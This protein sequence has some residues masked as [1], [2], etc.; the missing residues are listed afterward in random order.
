[1]MTSQHF[2][3][4]AK[5]SQVL[6]LAMLVGSI[7]TVGA[8]VAPTEFKTHPIESA[9]PLMGKVFTKL[10]GVMQASLILFSLAVVL[11]FLG[12]RVKKHQAV[13]NNEAVMVDLAVFAKLVQALRVV[14]SV[15]LVGVG[16]LLALEFIPVMTKYALDPNQQ[17][18]SQLEFD[19]LH[20][21][22]RGVFQIEASLGAVLLI[23]L[24]L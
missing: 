24:V 3:N 4:L 6:A 21:L 2:V 20:Q 13:L 7:I 19:Q 18:M 17:K 12:L 16:L 15:S 1:M 5:A 9:A 23:L 10:S 8:L 14:S 22:S 11:E